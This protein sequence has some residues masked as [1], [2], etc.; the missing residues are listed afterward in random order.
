MKYSA[1]LLLSVCIS[2]SGNEAWRAQEPQNAHSHLLSLL[3]GN[4]Q[5]VPITEG[6]LTIGTWQSIMLVELDGKRRRTVGIQV[7]G[8][9]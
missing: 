7:V 5:T 2:W 6:A 8:S 1:P 3:L 9:K 4:S